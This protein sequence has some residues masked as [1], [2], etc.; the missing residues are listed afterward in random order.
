MRGNVVMEQLVL[1]E[2]RLLFEK[3]PHLWVARVP[4]SARSPFCRL[5]D[6]M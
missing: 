6:V 1:G 5:G 2:G 4:V 3:S